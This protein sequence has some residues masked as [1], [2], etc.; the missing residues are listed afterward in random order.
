MEE[1][2]KAKQ[3]ALHIL[4]RMDKTEADLKAGLTRAGFSDEAIEAAIVYVKQYGYVDDQI[5]AEK[6]VRYHKAR[7][8]RQKIKYELINKGVSKEL[9]QLAFESCEDYDEL[10]ALRKALKKKWKSEEKP[11]E[12][13]LQKL[14]AAMA[15][16]GFSG[17]D[18]WQVFHEENLT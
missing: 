4:A 9:I 10:E 3:K 15:R 12:K 5:Y 16:Q 11:D 14:F 13:M 1:Q 2:K 8:S 7:K 17:H 18:I 6:Y